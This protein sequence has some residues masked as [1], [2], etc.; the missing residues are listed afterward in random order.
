MFTAKT[1]F[2]PRVTNDFRDDLINVT[3]R[4]QASSADADCDAGRLVVRTTQLPCAGFPNIK[5]ENAW[6]MV[7]ATSTTKAGDVVYAANTYE[8]P[9]LAGKTASSMPSARRR[10]ASAFRQDATA[11]SRRSFSTAI[12]HTASVSEM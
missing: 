4:Y 6:I 3:G 9:L 1:A 12:T 2:E 10:S 11:R 8:V 5:N 7:D